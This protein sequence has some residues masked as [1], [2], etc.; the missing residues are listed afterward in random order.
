MVVGDR[1]DRFVAE[2]SSPTRDEAIG[3]TIKRLRGELSQQNVADF[4]RER[5][6]EW[7][8]ATV[9]SIEKGKRPLRLSEAEALA[10]YFS[11][12]ILDLLAAP[13]ALWLAEA[14]SAYQAGLSQLSQWQNRV[15]D[16]RADVL[17]AISRADAYLAEYP[18]DPYGAKLERS[19][20][21]AREIAR[22]VG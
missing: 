17:H 13:P 2:I 4:M 19:L 9:W 22:V 6:F 8:Q 12:Q 7:A 16:L 18:D 11:V 15:E 14:I 20:E 3:Q 21:A 10:D 1:Y 5:G